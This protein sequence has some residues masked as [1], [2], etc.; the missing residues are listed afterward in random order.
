[1]D[2]IDIYRRTRDGKQ[3]DENTFDIDMVFPTL[4]ELIAKY[5]IQYDAEHPVSNDDALADRVFN[6]AVEFM[7]K[8]GIYCQDTGRVVS[9]SREEIL[10]AVS[11]N[12]HRRCVG[13]EKESRREW[14]VRKPDEH[15]RPWCHI[16]SGI[17]TSSDALF[18]K[19]VEGY[20]RIARA[21]SMAIPTLMNDPAGHYQNGEFA[22]HPS[23]V[24]ATIHNMRLAR[25][26]CENAERPGFPVFNV[27][28]SS[29]HAISTIAASHP[30][31][32]TRTSDGWLCAFY[33]EFKL[34]LDTLNKITFVHEIGGN[35]AGEA[36]VLLGGYCGGPEG[37]S[38]GVA[39]Y[40]IMTCLLNG[41][42]FLNFPVTLQGAI[43]TSRPLLWGLGVG[44]Q[45]ISRNMFISTYNSGYSAAGAGTKEYFYQS[46]AYILTGVTSGVTTGTPFPAAGVKTDGMTPLEALF[47]TEMVD[48]AAKLTRAEANPI[49]MKL[50]EKYEHTL[51]TPDLGKTFQELF[52]VDSIT[53]KPFYKQMFDEVKAELRAMGV[54]LAD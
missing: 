52:D 1:M 49:V 8:V 17:Y 53:P 27:V 5:D 36:S 43:S 54:P 16:G 6:A 37:L 35:I 20:A 23:E 9:F 40:A 33:P 48:A 51:N 46:A 7:E 39:V 13:G 21:D 30:N 32:G 2:L 45:A 41:T 11:E 47:H 10:K 50:L 24:M 4:L 34:K 12:G 19:L 44:S 29:S 3:V 31:C 26:A 25:K 42:Y 28:P 14:I 38:I 22:Y 18:M 15:S